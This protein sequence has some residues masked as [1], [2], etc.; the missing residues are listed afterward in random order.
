[1]KGIIDRDLAKALTTLKSRDHQKW[2]AHNIQ[3]LIA[4]S[5]EKYG[6][7]EKSSGLSYTSVEH[8]LKGLSI[9]QTTS[10]VLREFV[11]THDPSLLP[12]TLA[13]CDLDLGKFFGTIGQ[14]MTKTALAIEGD[15]QTYAQAHT[16]SGYMRLGRMSF[17]FRNDPDCQRLL[18][19]EEQYRPKIGSLPEVRLHWEGY[20]TARGS[21][22]YFA[23]LRC[24]EDLED[25]RA[26]MCLIEKLSASPS[27][28]ERARC[29]S[30][31]FEPERGQ[32]LRG[33]SILTKVAK[34]DRNS[35]QYN[36]VPLTD[37]NDET[38]IEELWLTQTVND[39]REKQRNHGSRGQKPHAKTNRKTRSRT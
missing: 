26:M 1:M 36:F 19:E 6:L 34:K 37:F 39:L 35:I 7:S 2:N 27:G 3:R 12:H 4:R 21:R 13:E 38:I 5:P 29:Y 14:K 23:V 32:Y 17:S 28:I 9:A 30:L 31:Q 8:A 24:R 10:R 25:G 22:T 11:H 18:V 15:Y 33:I 20:V 16:S